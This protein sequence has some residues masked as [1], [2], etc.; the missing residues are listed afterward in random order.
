[1]KTI[2]G[3]N[4]VLAGKRMAERSKYN[5]RYAFGSLAKMYEELPSRPV[6]INRWLVSLDGYADQ[7]VRLWFTCLRSGFEYLEVNYQLINPFKGLDAPKV[8]KKRRR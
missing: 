3:L 7:T 6:E 1:M 4:E 2:E 8:K 5:F